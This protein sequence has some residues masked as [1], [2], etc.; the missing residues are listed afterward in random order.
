MEDGEGH[1]PLAGLLERL[2]ILMQELRGIGNVTA[3][4]A[5]VDDRFDHLLPAL[6]GSD[7]NGG[8]AHVE[9]DRLLER[10][11]MQGLGNRQCFLRILQRLRV[12]VG[13]QIGVGQ[14]A[15]PQSQHLPTTGSA[16]MH[17]RLDRCTALPSLITVARSDIRLSQGD[18]RQRR[19]VVIGGG[20]R[21][22]LSEE[23]DGFVEAASQRVKLR[24]LDERA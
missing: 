12:F 11:A 22:R 1:L 14:I 8:N 18:L 21:L 10:I 5:G 24:Y 3:V 16:S 20:Q 4:D 7:V 6:H 17:E 19:L 13:S 9:K 23:L 2:A 15:Q